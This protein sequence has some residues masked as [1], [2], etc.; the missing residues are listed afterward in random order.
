MKA[1]AR[2]GFQAKLLSVTVGL[3]VLLT[4]GSLLTVRQQFG[5]QLRR[6]AER[7]VSD[8][9]HVL[10]SI[11][12]R[13]REQLGERGRLLAELPSLQTALASRQSELLE[14]LLIEVKSI[15]A[16]NLLWVTDPQ[17]IVLA[18][19]GEY[20]ALSSSLAEQPLVSTA[21]KMREATGFQL[22]GGEWWLVLT[23]PVKKSN[24]P[25]LLGTVSLSLLIGEAYV[26]R[27]SELIGTE[28]GFLFEGNSLWS[29]G[30]P[31]EVRHPIAAQ[32]PAALDRPAQE[33]GLPSEGR[34]F[35]L[36]RQVT[37][38]LQ[39]QVEPIGLLGIRLDESVIQRTTQAIG[40]IALLT[41]V[42]GTLL[43]IGAIRPITRRLEEAQAQ[44]LQAEKLASIGQL[45]AGV[46]HELNNPLM[47]IMGN[48]QLALRTL[49]SSKAQEKGLSGQ[50]KEL[51]EDLDCQTHQAKMVV[52]N[53]LDFTR[54]KPPA[55]VETNLHSLLEDSLKLVGHQ[56]S[57]QSIEVVKQFEKELPL[58]R[59][60]PDQI[61]QVLVN[62]ILNAVQAMSTGGTL[63]LKTKAT[64]N[65]VEIAVQDTGM[66]VP[67][68]SLKKVFDPFFTT[69]PVGQGT[70]LGLSLSYT[71]VQRHGGTIALSSR[72]NEGTTVT[73]WFPVGAALRENRP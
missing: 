46:A 54:I 65:S 71:I 11:L 33:L 16:A 2:F 25:S 30:W 19:T 28:V 61:K 52:N 13:S 1:M 37:V 26:A 60:D 17:G 36:A 20:P 47:V 69:K 3:L 67:K 35:W 38:G 42:I 73:I 64:E 56:A 53:L 55:Q 12:E 63:T 50:I 21:L 62:V 15:R 18:C 29:E 23:V 14:S 51:L 58:V 34:T 57:L 9:A 40:W 66:G 44:L 43:L 72:V 45:A 10:T 31:A 68:E 48:T 22:F 8:G 4:A 7:K 39:P 70:G 49:A 6:E 32:A 5:K 24:S 41:M 59:V 27:L